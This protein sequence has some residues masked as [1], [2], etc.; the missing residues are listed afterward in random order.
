MNSL[1]Y[2]EQGSGPAV[3]L[4]H[5][6]PMNQDVWKDFAEELNDRYQVITIDLPGFGKSKGLSE[7]FGI[8]D[9]AAAV[10]N[11]IHEKKY[12]K[13]VVVGHSLGGYVAL[14]LAELDQDAIAGMCLFHSTA[15]ADTEEKK[16][17]RNKVVDFIGKQGVH[18]FTSNFVSQLY[19]DPQHSSITRVK[20]IAVQSSMETVTGY[21]RAMRDRKDR[22]H[23]L[24][25]FHGPILFLAGEKDQGIPADTILR[26]ASL[27][28][29]AE[30]VIL[31]DVGHMGMFEAEAACL[32]NISGFIAKCTVTNS[33]GKV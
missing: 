29:R 9:V 16:Q 3:I 15:L 30:A 11:F 2:R 31:P 20:S 12:H 23:V 24:K 32:K 14:A 26:Q 18:A 25:T 21:T 33:P 22:T 27:N 7:G 13:P 10:L 28:A 17:S 8:E 1:N 4:I 5:G 19:F 6:F